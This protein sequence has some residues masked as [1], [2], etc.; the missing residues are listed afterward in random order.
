VLA[1]AVAV[2]LAAAPL[3]HTARPPVQP[4]PYVAAARSSAA[5][6]KT[7]DRE[8]AN[9]VMYSDLWPL[10][11]W[12][13]GT[14]VHP[15]PFFEDLSAFEHELEKSE[16]DYFFTLRARRFDSYSEAHITGAVTVLQRSAVEPTDL[17]RVLYLGKSWDN[18]IE[19]LVDYDLYLESTAGRYGFE[20]TSFL[21]AR[22][23]EELTGYDAVAV[24]GFRWRDRAAGEAALQEYLDSGGS[25]VI[26]A[27]QNLAGL[28][29]SVLDTIMFDT[30]IRRGQLPAEAQIEVS[31][32]LAARHP[33]LTSIT[34]APWID[35]G[36]G[37]WGGAVYE[38]RPGTPP[39]KVL[40]TVAGKPL[41]QV[42]QVGKGRV[43]WLSYNLAWHA[44]SGESAGEARLVRA[45]FSEAL[46][47]A[48]EVRTRDE[49]P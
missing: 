30:V 4:D 42:Q 39:L 27:S 35:E 33:G 44:F 16:A 22:S 1:A 23:G 9:R 14:R 25:I 38:A 49:A 20:G 12:Y 18:Y 24:A 48:V 7:Y 32:S 37:P 46:A 29:H 13:L 31:P 2:V 6:L 19:S 17:P 34:T 45:V 15:M 3:V 8:Y 11:S 43:Y 21:D 26:D 10:S 41:V 40:A 28:A 47:T 36:G 5:W